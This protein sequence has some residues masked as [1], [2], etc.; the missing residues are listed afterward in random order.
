MNSLTLAQLDVGRDNNF[1]LLRFVAASL[2]VLTHA[3]GLTG[4]ESTEPLLRSAGISLGSLAVDIFFVVS[5]F[6]I[7]KSWIR[8]DDPVRFFFARFMRIYPALWI[9]VCACALVL[10]PLF[11]TLPLGDYFRHIGTF[12]FLVEN[13]TLLISGTVDR[14]PVVFDALQSHSIN[15]PLWTLPYELKLYIGLAI[16]GMAGS[17]R[18]R[19]TVVVL[20]LA[21]FIGFCAAWL[22]L[23]EVSERATDTLRFIYFF[24]SGAA[25]YLFGERVRIG[26]PFLAGLFAVALV[27]GYLLDSPHQLRLLLGLL[28]PSLVMVAAFV[29][30]GRIRLFNRV[31]DYSFGIYIFAMPI[32]Q[33]IIAL[34]NNASVA[35]NS[36][37]SYTITLLLAILSWH[38][39][40]R[41]MVSYAIPEPL[42]RLGSML[43]I[44]RS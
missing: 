16:L 20:A 1:N 7:T 44:R 23:I 10:G 6:L 39:V 15:A 37:A 3:F 33:S 9:S 38:F 11:T 41:K 30:R 40:E 35:A 2:V 28:C 31:G 12:K 22:H 25:F 29:P 36:F 18:S 8:R 34:T 17:L 4:H 26:W 27:S 14:L 21:S 24:S 43:R 32:Q 19:T 13:S 5:G 42:V